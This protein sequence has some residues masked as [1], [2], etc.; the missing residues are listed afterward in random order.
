ME[1]RRVIEEI[2]AADIPLAERR[3]LM[4]RAATSCLAV[5]GGRA[6]SDACQASRIESVEEILA[7]VGGGRRTSVSEAKATL[8]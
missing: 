3:R 5:A 7:L 4:G 2:W 1:L 8:R 6:T